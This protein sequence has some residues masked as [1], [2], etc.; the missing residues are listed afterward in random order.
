MASPLPKAGLTDY[1][2]RR[3][4]NIRRNE[5]ILASLRR[6]AA[7]F[8]SSIRP[9]APKRPK[10]EHPR[11]SPS[12]P[13]GP[14]VLRRSLRTRGIPPGE[15]SASPGANSSP[16][17]PPSPTKPRTTRFSS[18]LAS[19]LRDATATESTP[20]PD[21]GICAADG[22]DAGRELVLRPANVRKVVPER[23][24]SVRVLPLAD[25]TV[26][27]VGNKLG[28]IGFWDVDGLVED[29]EDGHGA[30]G[31][32]EYFPHRGAVGGIVVHPAEPR[33]VIIS[34]FANLLFLDNVQLLLLCYFNCC[35]CGS[36][37]LPLLLNY[38]NIW[39]IGCTRLYLWD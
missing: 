17:T 16:P 39:Y 26:V 12:S 5:I 22:F 11:A 3:E 15:S 30:D 28:H 6:E 7:E 23:I 35:S 36:S 19:S 37:V 24:L 10:K 29:D 25:R 1:E 4:E 8:S 18:S 33:K 32:F 14:V 9:S 31:V 13:S 20:R 27:V 38:L 34:S 21:G 2:R